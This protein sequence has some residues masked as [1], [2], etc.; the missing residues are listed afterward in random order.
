MGRA[1]RVIVVNERMLDG[2]ELKTSDSRIS[3]M[4]EFKYMD[5]LCW[6][7]MGSTALGECIL[8]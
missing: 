3:N 1:E 8:T 7:N 6:R 4:P 2:N 5:M